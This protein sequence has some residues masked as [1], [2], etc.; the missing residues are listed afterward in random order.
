MVWIVGFL[1]AAGM[2]ASGFAARLAVDRYHIA[3][4]PSWRAENTTRCF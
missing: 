3:W 1:I 4:M 2:F